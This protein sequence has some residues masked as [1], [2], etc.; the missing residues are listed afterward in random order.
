MVSV[1]Y[2]ST[3]YHSLKIQKPIVAGRPKPP[4]QAEVCQFVSLFRNAESHIFPTPD[5]VI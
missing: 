5:L 3:L 1:T 2:S 4:L